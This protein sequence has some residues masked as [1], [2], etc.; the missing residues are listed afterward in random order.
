MQ[1]R[2]GEWARPRV[3]RS[4]F[5]VGLGDPPSEEVRLGGDWKEARK[6]EDRWGRGSGHMVGLAGDQQPARRAFVCGV[7]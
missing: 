2:V 6:G 1:K 3:G 7:G 4:V 5:E